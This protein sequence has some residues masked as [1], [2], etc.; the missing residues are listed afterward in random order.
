MASS[1][2]KIS[3]EHIFL[4]VYNVVRGRLQEG[5][6]GLESNSV[7]WRKV[8][9]TRGLCL[10]ESSNRRERLGTRVTNKEICAHLSRHLGRGAP[11]KLPL[12]GCEL[13][14]VE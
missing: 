12:L 7:W 2:R 5:Y 1:P 6:V 8:G 10:P 11:P 13:S 14:K 4:A 9:G 3:L